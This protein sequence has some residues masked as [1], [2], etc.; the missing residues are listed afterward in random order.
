MNE[1][2]KKIQLLILRTYKDYYT[3]FTYVLSYSLHNTTS[4]LNYDNV[5]YG[6]A[7]VVSILSHII[8]IINIHDG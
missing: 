2:A 6:I 7:T 1:Q 4:M 8:H 5:N 3:F